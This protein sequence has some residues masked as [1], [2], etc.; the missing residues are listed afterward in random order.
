MSSNYEK[1]SIRI[2]RIDVRQPLA[3]SPTL[4]AILLGTQITGTPLEEAD[5][6]FGNEFWN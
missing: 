3:L 1:P 5:S 2:V 4:T 6:G